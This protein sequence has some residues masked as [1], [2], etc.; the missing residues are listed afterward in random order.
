MKLDDEIA[1]ALG[2]MYKPTPPPAPTTTIADLIAESQKLI[3]GLPK[4]P[5][6]IR[7]TEIIPEGDA[8]LFPFEWDGSA[9]SSDRRAN[10]SG[11][12]ELC[13]HPA[14]W[15]ELVAPTIARIEENAAGRYVPVDQARP[16]EAVSDGWRCMGI[17][18]IDDTLKVL[19]QRARREERR[20]D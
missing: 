6:R 3:D 4:L 11:P 20:N 5:D 19:G 15:T 2:D 7:L 16:L 18:V 13:I 8:F 9:P 17:P 12:H 10:D 1:R 14:T